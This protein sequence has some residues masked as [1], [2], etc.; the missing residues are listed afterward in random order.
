MEGIIKIVG[1][2][3]SSKYDGGGLY[4]Y[5]IKDLHRRICQKAGKQS[6]HNG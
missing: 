2:V 6:N 5:T 4:T 1:D 3:V